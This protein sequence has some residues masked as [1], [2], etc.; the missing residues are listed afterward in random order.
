MNEI[1]EYLFNEKQNLRKL[2]NLID[3]Y[4]IPQELERKI[5]YFKVIS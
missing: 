4:L 1:K 3:K 2:S 5:P